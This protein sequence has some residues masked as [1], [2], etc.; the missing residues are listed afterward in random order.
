MIFLGLS[1]MFNNESLRDLLNPFVPNAHLKKLWHLVKVNIKTP[2][3]SASII[4]FEQLNVSWESVVLL[5]L[6]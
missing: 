2:S 4:D 6:L 3:S 1:E 5:L